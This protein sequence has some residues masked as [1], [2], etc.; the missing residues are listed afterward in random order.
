MPDQNEQAQPPLEEDPVATARPILPKTFDKWILTAILL[1]AA[2]LRVACLEDAPPGF[3]QDEA[4]TGY[5]AYCLATS[6]ENRH[7]QFLPVFFNSFGDY[8]EGLHRYLIVPFIGLFG[9]SVW[10]VRVVSAVLGVGVVFVTY[11]LARQMY[12]GLGALAAAAVAAITPWQIH[13]SRVAVRDIL[14]PLVFG[15]GTYCILRALHEFSEQ[16]RTSRSDILLTFGALFWALTWYTY[17][18]ARL[19]LPLMLL[20]FAI[21]FRNS[22]IQLWRMRPRIVAAACLCFVVVSLPLVIEYV[23][24]PDQLGARMQVITVG[25][26]E[27][28]LVSLSTLVSMA[29]NYLPHFSPNHLFLKGD[30]NPFLFMGGGLLL[31]SIAPLILLG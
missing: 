7:G 17:T 21:I 27:T 8:E 10:S 28:S 3:F 18:V 16:R 13:L 1:C 4:A 26:M 11:L 6:G 30:P 2:F 20:G 24:H 25:G 29:K 12:G 22:I 31:P 5:D 9:L 19:F 23:C 15:F 14:L